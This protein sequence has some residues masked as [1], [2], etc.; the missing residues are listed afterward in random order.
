MPKKEKI[1]KENETNGTTGEIPKECYPSFEYQEKATEKE[2]NQT[3]RGIALHQTILNLGEA[4]DLEIEV[5]CG[6]INHI[7]I[8]LPKTYLKE[9]KIYKET[10]RKILE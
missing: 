10:V 5:G 4:F 9:M 6:N 2:N 3:K 8:I 1:K 7:R